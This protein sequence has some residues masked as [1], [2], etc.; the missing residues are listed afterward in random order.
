MTSWQKT[1]THP[2]FWQASKIPVLIHI[3]WQ[4]IKIPVLIHFDDKPAKDRYSSIFKTSQHKTNTHPFL[5]QA[6]KIPVLIHFLCQ[7]SIMPVLIHFLRQASIRPILIHFYDNLAK[8][9]HSSIFFDKPAKY[10]YSSISLTSWHKT[11]AHPFYIG[12]YIHIYTHVYVHKYTSQKECLH[13][14]SVVPFF[15]STHHVK[16]LPISSERDI[17]G[18]GI[19]ND[20]WISHWKRIFLMI[21]HWNVSIFFGRGFS[22]KV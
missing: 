18:Y 2:F 19:Q 22:V 3:L 5:W 1:G 7:A 10:R 20:G 6:G 13:I 4:A 21:S 14:L 8:D 12:M 16:H 17:A 9:R 11:G 15:F